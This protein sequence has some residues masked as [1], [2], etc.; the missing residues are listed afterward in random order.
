MTVTQANTLTASGDGSICIF[1]QSDAP[2]TPAT[3][4]SPSTA[5]SQAA[6]GDQGSGVHFDN[7]FS[8]SL[9]VNGGGDISASSR[10]AVRFTTAS[11]F[12]SAWLAIT[13]NGTINGDIDNAGAG[14]VTGDALVARRQL[15][16]A[17]TLDNRGT[18]TGARSSTPMCATAARWRSASAA[19]PTR[20][21][22]A[23]I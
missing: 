17:L 21:R 3:S 4:T 20:P 18:L 7:G 9:I 6:R 22:S 13:N 8:N 10:T 2:F 11:N 16:Q 15:I 19:S 12:T 23:A 1:A 5:W 14:S